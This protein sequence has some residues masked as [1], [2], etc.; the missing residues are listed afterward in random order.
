MA[1]LAPAAEEV[2]LHELLVLGLDALGDDT[3]QLIGELRSC[4]RAGCQR[5]ARWSQLGWGA[6]LS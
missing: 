3:G 4:W 6:T 1:G 5:V 2:E